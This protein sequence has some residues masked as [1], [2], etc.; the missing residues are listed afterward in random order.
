M[1]FGTR[2][3]ETRRLKKL[4]QEQLGKGLGTDGKDVTKAVVSGWEQDQHSPRAD[5]L[6]MM[7]E[8]L[9]C[10]ADFLLLGRS[11]APSGLSP[12][13]AELAEAAERLKTERWRDWTVN[14]LRQAVKLAQEAEALESQA[15]SSSQNAN[16]RAGSM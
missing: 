5:Q 4:T 8:R 9:D 7:C 16:K 2:L 10:S 15:D 6:R 12:E 1:S 11:A 14:A 3:A 13:M